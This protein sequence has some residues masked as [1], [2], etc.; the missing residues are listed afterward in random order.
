MITRST[1]GRRRRHCVD[2]NLWGEPIYVA[3]ARMRGSG[4]AVSAVLATLPRCPAIADQTA[5]RSARLCGA[6][7]CAF[8]SQ[9]RSAI[10]SGSASGYQRRHLRGRSMGRLQKIK[11]LNCCRPA[12]LHARAQRPLPGWLHHTCLRTTAQRVH[13]IQ[14]EIAQC[15]YM[16]EH[17]G[18]CSTA[19]MAP[20]Q[21]LLEQI[22]RPCYRCKRGA[23]AR[24][25]P[26]ARSALA[27]DTVP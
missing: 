8:D 10:V 7:G 26:A 6:A 27:S 12:A 24:P 9:H 2:R 11:W 14:F 16:D 1:R 20:L 18:V 22:P 13:A 19:S 5:N 21:A 15:A 17:S 4:A 3:P 25:H 23:V